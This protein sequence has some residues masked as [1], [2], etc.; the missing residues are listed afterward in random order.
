MTIF[1]AVFG[2]RLSLRRNLIFNIVTALSICIGIAAIVMISE[3]FEHLET[4]LENALIAEAYEVAGQIDPEEKDLGLN[5]DGLRFSGAEGIYRYTIFEDSGAM[6]A[7]GER[8][9]HLPLLLKSLRPGRTAK[10]TMPSGRIG[11]ILRAP[12]EGQDFY[13]L[14]TTSKAET[15][16]KKLPELLHEI[17]EQIQWILLGIVT[18]IVAA[19]LAARRSLKPLD[20]ISR[21]AHDIGPNTTRQRLS[22][23][24]LPAEIVPLVAAVNGAFDRLEQG[25]KAQREFSS[26]VAHE[27]RT[28]L[29]VLRSSIDR[30]E[31]AELRKG[32]TEDIQRLDQMFEQLI[33]LSRAESLGP[34]LFE[35]VNLHDIAVREATER[36]SS[37]IRSG[38]MLAV[39]GDTDAMVM[40]H[41]GLLSIALGN[42]VRNALNYSPEG[43]E[44]EIE[45]LSDPPGWRVLDRGIGVP[46][47]IKEGLFERFNRGEDSYGKIQGSGIGLAIV[48]SVAEAH[49]A[50]VDISDRDGGGSVFSFRFN[51]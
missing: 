42:L 11:V 40:G 10:I 3:F 49:G 18:V 22:V 24:R 29:A 20:T 9:D 26:N 48:K 32:L 51:A 5:L 37:A 2:K 41:L 15:E 19:V 27:V 44:V 43:T 21:Q 7:G 35:P 34:T 25:Y 12:V 46:E 30:I 4:N 45:V 50:V 6:L 38:K 39:T 33:D 23:E 47:K 16:S 14:V 31:D 8:Y 17:E 36:A 1:S 13:I 28:P